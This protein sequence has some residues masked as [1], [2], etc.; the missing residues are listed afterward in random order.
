MTGTNNTP[1][2][3]ER[4]MLLDYM[5]NGFLD[6]LIDLFRH[7]PACIPIVVD[8]IIDERI[9]VRLGAT[10]LIEEL[11]ITHSEHILKLIPAIG[12][13]LNH[14]S[15]VVRGDCAYILGMLKSAES[16]SYLEQHRDE[17]NPIVLE[18]IEEAIQEIKA[19]LK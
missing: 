15:P 7:Q 14:E 3:T 19:T 2:S 11:T 6:N 18:I 12:N 10:A 16:L 8:M 1:C 17:Q 13:L 4:E 9:R 5:E